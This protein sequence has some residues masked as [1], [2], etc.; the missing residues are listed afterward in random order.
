MIYDGR[1]NGTVSNFYVFFFFGTDQVNSDNYFVYGL[2][3][4]GSNL[5]N[6][7]TSS[8]PWSHQI[9]IFWCLGWEK[10]KCKMVRVK[11]HTAAAFS[12]YAEAE[13][14]GGDPTRQETLI[15]ECTAR[16]HATVL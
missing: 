5:L 4:S 6:G 3:S 9:Q 15:M 10:D 12:Y 16:C 8:F 11:V 14:K 2:F 13:G 7:F 1:S